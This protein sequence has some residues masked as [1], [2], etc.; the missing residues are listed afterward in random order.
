MH[1]HYLLLASSAVD[2]AFY[3]T[4]CVGIGMLCYRLALGIIGA[5][6]DNVVLDIQDAEEPKCSVFLPLLLLGQGDGYLH[7]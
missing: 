7:I 3:A 1:I 2:E 4:P 5:A 6:M